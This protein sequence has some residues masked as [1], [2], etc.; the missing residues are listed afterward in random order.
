MLAIA[1]HATP[2]QFVQDEHYEPPA[3]QQ[4]YQAPEPPTGGSG[5]LRNPSVAAATHRSPAAEQ[6]QL[7][8]AP[9][10][11]LDDAEGTKGP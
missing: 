1:V 2:L 11:T 9:T 8:A 5:A 3:S 6:Q 10:F 7:G 4:P